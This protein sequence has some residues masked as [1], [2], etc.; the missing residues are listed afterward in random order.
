M[1]REDDDPPPTYADGPSQPVRAS[2]E[3]MRLRLADDPER[4]EAWVEAYRASGWRSP[5]VGRLRVVAK[6]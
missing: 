3:T 1:G 2:I 4:F 5:P 6:D